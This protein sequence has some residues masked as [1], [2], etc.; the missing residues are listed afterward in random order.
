ME[1]ILGMDFSALP[2]HKVDSSYYQN[3]IP[4]QEMKKSY[5]TEAAGGRNS[6]T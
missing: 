2:L 3:H 4:L 1:R 5:S 6:P